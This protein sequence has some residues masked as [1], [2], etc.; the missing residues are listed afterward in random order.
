MAGSTVEDRVAALE[1]SLP[2]ILALLQEVARNVGVLPAEPPP[3]PA[4]RLHVVKGGR[5]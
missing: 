3:D 2:V 1:A 4:P 5:T